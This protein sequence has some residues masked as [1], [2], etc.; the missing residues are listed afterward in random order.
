M[1]L[2]HDDFIERV[3]SLNSAYWREGAGYRWE[4]MSYVIEEAKKI[5]GN[6]II[7]AGSSGM[8]LN[9][10]SY[11]FD[12]PEHNL[13]IIPYNFKNKKFDLFIA[14]Q[15]WEHI[16]N[17]P[18]AFREVMRISKNAILSFPYK[19]Q[20]GDA[21]HKGID[22]E[23]IKQWSCGVKPDSIKL[24]KNRVVYTWRF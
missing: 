20:H 22:D 17:Q 5:G 14:L 18:E 7:E 15:V 2:N 6:K 12:Y 24:I 9:N 1:W 13:D 23:K 11:L 4:Y 8:P 16:D 19:W 21:R 10:E 3:N